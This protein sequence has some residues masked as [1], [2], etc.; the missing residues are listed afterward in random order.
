[1]IFLEETVALM[2][3]DNPLDRLKAEYWQARIRY[4]RLHD[5]LVLVEQGF[6]TVDT[7]EELSLLNMQAKIMELY[8]EVLKERAK[9]LGIKLYA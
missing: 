9:L 8:L 1:M 6:E 3:S 5:Y 2:K 4:D 7:R